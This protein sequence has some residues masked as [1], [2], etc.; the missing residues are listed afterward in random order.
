MAATYV[1][2]GGELGAFT[3]AQAVLVIKIAPFGA[4]LAPHDFFAYDTF[5]FKC[6]NLS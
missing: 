3:I 5:S 4:I 2:L 1:Y 6:P